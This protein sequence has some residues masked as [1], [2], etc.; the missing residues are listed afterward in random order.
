[1]ASTSGNATIAARDLAVVWHPCTQMK[2]HERLPLI[3]IA[4]AEGVWL[5]DSAPLR[6]G[7][8]I[9]LRTKRY[10]ARGIVTDMPSAEKGATA[11]R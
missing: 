9:H 11:G 8:G 5:Y 1:M 4:R 6:S 2:D 7:T 3:P 10:E